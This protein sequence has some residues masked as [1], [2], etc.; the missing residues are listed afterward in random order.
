MT[1]PEVY[2]HVADIQKNF[3]A[4]LDAG[5]VA[6]QEVKDVGR[7]TLIASVEDADGNVI[8]LLQSP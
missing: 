4:L 5:A 6:R 2:W 1:G 8:G 7:G 3:G